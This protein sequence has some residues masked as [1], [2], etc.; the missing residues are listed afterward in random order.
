MIPKMDTVDTYQWVLLG[1][2]HIEL[3]YR[4]FTKV[5]KLEYLFT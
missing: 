5:V 3:H 4:A 1:T 2:I